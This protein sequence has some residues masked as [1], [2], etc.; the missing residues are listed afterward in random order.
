MDGWTPVGRFFTCALCSAE[1][2][3]AES[4]HTSPAKSRTRD[5]HG[6]I[7]RLSAFLSQQRVEK[8]AAD[9]ALGV[10][11]DAT[12]FCK[13]CRHFYR[14]PFIDKCLLHERPTGPMDDC[15]DYERKPAEE[16]DD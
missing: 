1:L 3:P 11:E 10:T 13:D 14:H 12:R 2:G 7:D 9:Q 16:S 8:K 4:A 15:P 5:E 6:S